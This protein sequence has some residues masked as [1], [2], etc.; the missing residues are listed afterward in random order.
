MIVDWPETMDRFTR[1]AAFVRVVESG[2]F[3]TA[4]AKLGLSRAAASKYVRQLEE[5]LGVRLLNRTTRRLSL[6]EEGA[7]FF[8][9]ATRI[10][11]ELEAAE[12]EASAGAGEARG[13]LRL[14]APVS[15][16]RRHLGPAIAE[17][18]RRHPHV[19]I[20]LTLEDRFVDLVEDGFDAAI[21]I[22]RL[23]DSSL[24][25]RRLC[26]TRLVLAA[27]PSYWRRKGKPAT[28]QALPLEDCFVYTL[29]AAGRSWRLI[30]FAGREAMLQAR[31]ALV[32][33]NGDVLRAAALA[34]AGIVLLPDFIVGED[35][36]TGRLE[37]ALP[38][39]R[40]IDLGI[41]AV[42]PSGRHVPTRLRLFLDF[43][44]QELSSPPWAVAPERPVLLRR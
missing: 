13:T 44:A 5:H 21:R 24:V 11:A 4:A 29:Q 23:A 2:S 9:R 3:S 12:G 19:Q 15:F 34:G 1:L 6:T 35:V 39:W 20:A 41:Q 37:T 7:A 32:A 17:F 31:G 30:D 26:S 42:W 38:G 16:G 40:G 33:N 14:S 25:S 36:A 27:A 22:G 43:L 10:L 8:E 18:L 28:P